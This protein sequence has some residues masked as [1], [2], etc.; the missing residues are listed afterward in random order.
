MSKK[1]YD[2]K[3]SKNNLK[4]VRLNLHKEKDADLI[5]HLKTLNSQG[6]IKE[7]IRQDMNSLSPI[8]N[9]FRRS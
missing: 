7:L 6:Y 2:I 8:S 4:Q 3:Y 1:D 9:S 5:G